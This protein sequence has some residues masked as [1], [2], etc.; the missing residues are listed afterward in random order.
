[1]NDL[2][3]RF[4][5]SIFTARL[6]KPELST[7]FFGRPIDQQ[8]VFCSIAI[9]EYISDCPEQW[10]GY[11]AFSIHLETTCVK[12]KSKLSAFSYCICHCYS[13]I[14]NL[15]EPTTEERVSPVFGKPESV[16]II[17]VSL[18]QNSVC[19]VLSWTRRSIVRPRITWARYLSDEII[20]SFLTLFPSPL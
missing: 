6:T 12:T 4:D 13:D 7:L 14:I 11:I 9:K 15:N 18:Y 20:P 3:Q 5:L 8:N 1:M 19:W 2:D 16:L 17:N 10:N